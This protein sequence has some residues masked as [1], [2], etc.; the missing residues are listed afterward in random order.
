[1]ELL[2]FFIKDEVPAVGLSKFKVKKDSYSYE[3]RL[4]I[5]FSKPI[6]KPDY[7]NNFFLL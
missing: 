7:S 6:F 3:N 4:K 2:K 5:N 1:M